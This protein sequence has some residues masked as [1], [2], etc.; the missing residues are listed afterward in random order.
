MIN[1]TGVL[2]EVVYEDPDL[3]EVAVKA[4]NRGFGGASSFYTTETE[5]RDIAASLKGF[6]TSSADKREI[7]LG[8]KV[9]E[10]RANG[11]KLR[12]F[13]RDGLGHVGVEVKI[14]DDD[15]NPDVRQKATLFVATEAAA[16]DVFVAELMALAEARKGT[17]HLKGSD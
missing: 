5:L 1:E 2:I 12:F 8:E 14:V 3:I 7:Q 11:I 16:V 15:I 10:S 9:W 4:T 6:P 17:A 13:C